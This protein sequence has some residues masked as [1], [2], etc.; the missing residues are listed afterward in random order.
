MPR[1]PF[2]WEVH[3]RREVLDDEVEKLRELPYTIWREIVK[4]PMTRA[5]VGR[6]GRNYRLRVRAAYDGAED[7]RVSVWL[8]SSRLRRRLLRSG[9]VI[10]PDNQFVG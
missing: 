8:L 5:V 7:I 2:V 1:S 9:F 6:D 4:T 10:S 3:V